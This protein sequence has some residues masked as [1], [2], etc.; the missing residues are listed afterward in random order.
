MNIDA[1]PRPQ[2][3][4]FLRSQQ[5]ARIGCQAD[6]QIFVVP[7]AY[8][9]EQKD[10]E[11]RSILVHS[12]EG[13]KVH[14]MRENPHI[15]VEVDQIDDMSSWKTVVADGDFEEIRDKLA[16][17][18]ALATLTHRLL[19][20]SAVA[21]LERGEDPF[22]PPGLDAPAVL[23]RVRLREITGRVATP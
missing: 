6:G 5:L 14:M 11:V 23:F 16:Q 20:E 3:D 12:F 17:Q 19:P 21:R 15:C 8:A 18:T 13:R 9:P 7:I 1:L 10:G 4:Q 22:R 2:I